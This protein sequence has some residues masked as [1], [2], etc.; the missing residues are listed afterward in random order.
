MFPTSSRRAAHL[1]RLEHDGFRVA[2][3]LP[4]EPDRPLRPIR[5]IG[6][7]LLALKALFL[8]TVL[9]DEAL[10]DGLLSGFAERNG[11]VE[12]LT[13]TERQ[14]WATPRAQAAKAHGPTIGWRLENIWALAWVLG[15]E[16]EL[17]YLGGMVGPEQIDP[18]FRAF[19]PTFGEGELDAWVATLEPRDPATV[20]AMEDLLYCVHNAVRSAQLGGDT[21]PEGFHPLSDGG[22]VHE[23]RHVLTWALSP[24]VAWDDTDLST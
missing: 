15:H 22:T 12:A 20:N 17:G 14:I 8:R 18:I 7:R 10:P 24:G 2:A 5:E 13:P 21:V 23:R 9:P 1:A 3:S 16:I 11:L 4:E 6:A 19:T